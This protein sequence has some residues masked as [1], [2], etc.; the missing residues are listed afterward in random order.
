MKKLK[1]IRIDGKTTGGTRTRLSQVIPLST[2][3]IV[4]I[5]PVYACNFKCN[6][7]IHSVPANKRGYISEQSFMDYELYKKCIDDLCEFPEKLKMLRFAG[8]GE[9]LLHK[10]IAKMVKYAAKK[11]VTDSIDIVTNGSLLTHEL[12]KELIDAGLSKLRVSIQGISAKKY[13]GVSDVKLDFDKFIENLTYFYKIKNKTKIYIKIIDCALEKN[14]EQKFLNIFGD[15]CDEIA[16]E[17]LLPAVTQIDYSLISKGNKNDLTQN[18]LAINNVEV[19]PQPFYLMQINPEGNVVPCCAMETTYVLGNCNS[20]SLVD[21][22]K[23]KKYLNFRKTHLLKQKEVYSVCRDCKQYKYAMFTEDIL[24]N[25]AKRLLKF[26][27]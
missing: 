11:Q 9:P 18:G 3:Y 21:I 10:D 1:A 4:Q 14:E 12:S 8:T 15:I 26:F 22:W 23:G 19:C 24:D 7:C 27:K 5:F 6:Y 17:H 20:E 2:P 16:I 13:K 25:D